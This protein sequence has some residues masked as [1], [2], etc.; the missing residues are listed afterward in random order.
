MRS[1]HECGQ[2]AEQLGRHRWR[3]LS[4]S[5]STA[6]RPR[7]PNRPA[8]ADCDRAVWSARGIRMRLAR[9][10]RRTAGR[11]TASRRGS[12]VRPGLRH[13]CSCCDRVPVPLMLTLFPCSIMPLPPPN[14]PEPL[15]DVPEAR[16]DLQTPADTRPMSC[17]RP[18]GAG[19]AP[20]CHK[21]AAAGAAMDDIVTPSVWRY[22]HR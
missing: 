13:R 21:E 9:S 6:S 16:R 10:D 11:G 18:I 22:P 2:P 19:K 1:W 7:T 17:P 15:P 5:S 14:P 4:P 12:T 8:V 20:R 3:A